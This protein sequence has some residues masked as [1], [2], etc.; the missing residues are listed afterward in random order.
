ML[1]ARQKMAMISLATVMSKPSSRGTP[2]ALPPRPH[3]MLRSWRSFMSTTRFHVILRTSMPSSLPL[4]MCA[5]SSAAS[6]LLAAPMAW[7][8]PVKCRLM[9][10]MGMTWAYPPPAAPPLMPN[11]GP[12][13]GSRSATT[14]F[15][16]RFCSASARPTVVV[17]L[18]SPAG[19][20]LMAV[21]STSLPGVCCSSRS[22]L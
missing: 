8:S 10:S 7:K 13:L 11:T 5:S 9:S 2:L 19:V 14:G 17:V 16:P 12:R 3:T 6:R 1:V 18:P 22:R 21:T 4:W 20:G 15:L